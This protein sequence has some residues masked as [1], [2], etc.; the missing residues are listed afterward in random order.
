MSISKKQQRRKEKRKRI[1]SIIATC[2]LLDTSITTN[3]PTHRNSDID[4]FVVKYL[5]KSRQL[6][7]KKLLEQQRIPPVISQK[8][9]DEYNL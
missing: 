7:K 9:L 5:L 2:Q 6:A 4:D 8:L 1:A 3:I